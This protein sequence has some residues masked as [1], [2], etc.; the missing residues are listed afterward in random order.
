MQEYKQDIFWNNIP[1]RKGSS[2]RKLGFLKTRLLDSTFFKDVTN[3][4]IIWTGTGRISALEQMILTTKSQNKIRKNNLEF[5]FYLYEPLCAKIGEYN[6]SFYSEFDSDVDLKKITSDEFESIRI[7]TK[8]NNITNFKIF[9]S[10]YR[11][12]LIKDNYP[13]LKI[14]CLDIFIREIADSYKGYPKLKNKISKKFWCGN[15]RYTAHRHLV[16]SYLTNFNGIYTWNLKCSY[17]ELKKNTWFDLDRLKIDD[18]IRYDKISKGIEYLYNN[19][20]SIDITLNPVNV[21]EFQE[22]FIPG[23]NAPSWST[24]FLQ[25]YRSCFCAIINETRYAQPFGY[26]SEKTL[27]AMFS[28]LPIILVAPP[29][30]LQYLKDLGFKTFDRWWDESYDQEENHY[31]RMMMIF[32]LIDFINS[33]DMNELEKIYEEMQDILDHNISIIRS[34]PYNSRPL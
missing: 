23:D 24:D 10:D 13:D 7:F 1:H 31:K 6:R 11:I 4:Y 9:T 15:W 20:L 3:P 21:E 17:N 12:E 16:T 25:S 32:D 14:C 28:R 27:T 19:V 8:N 33:K 5:Y 18:S 22:V 26:F 34:L 30:S 2:F 29:Y